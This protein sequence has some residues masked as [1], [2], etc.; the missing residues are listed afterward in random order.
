MMSRVITSSILGHFPMFVSFLKS[1][2]TNDSSSQVY[3][4]KRIRGV[5]CDYN[6]FASVIGDTFDAS[7]IM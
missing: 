2:I 7:C 5:E 4:K 3:I 6:E 1:R